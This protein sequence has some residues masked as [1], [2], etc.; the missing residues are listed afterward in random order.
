[1]ITLD[2]A[3]LRATGGNSVEDGLAAYY[4]AG[5]ATGSTPD[6]L[7]R[8]YAMSRAVGVDP[9]ATTDDIWMTYLGNL[10]FSG[11]LDDRLLQYWRNGQGNG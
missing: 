3:I 4:L 10:G 8:S 2:D 9:N 1:M 5:G 7:S 11:S 6:E